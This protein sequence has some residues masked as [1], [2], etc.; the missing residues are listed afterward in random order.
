ME[1]NLNFMPTDSLFVYVYDE[2]DY[3]SECLIKYLQSHSF[4]KLYSEVNFHL[5]RD[6]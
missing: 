6:S 5:K 1:Q 4:D 3:K 2:A